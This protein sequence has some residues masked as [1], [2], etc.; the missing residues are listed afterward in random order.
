MGMSGLRRCRQ[1]LAGLEL[2][3]RDQ[4]RRYGSLRKNVVELDV[5]VV[6]RRSVPT[7]EDVLGQHVS[8]DQLDVP[9]LRR[10][11]E[12]EAAHEDAVLRESQLEVIL[13][14]LEGVAELLGHLA[15]L[16]TREPPRVVRVYP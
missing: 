7:R 16:L 14:D 1:V 10:P 4:L 8:Q 11:L 12:H 2:E 13:P 15:G 5:W 3:G 6:L 9:V